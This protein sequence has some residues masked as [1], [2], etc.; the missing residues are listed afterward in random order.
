MSKKEVIVYTDGGARGNPGPA[1]SGAALFDTEG[2]ELATAKRFLG[3]ATNNVAEYTAIIIG[4][5]LAAE[6]GATH[7][8]V[9][10]DS[11]LACK[12]LNREYRVKN[13]QLA[14]LFMRVRGAEGPF[15]SVRYVHVRREQN[16]RADEL[17]N[18]AID[19][20]EG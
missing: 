7:V 17:V 3:E 11:E 14:K 16:K 13:E 8:E 6:Q 15:A 19:E 4:L 12:Q 10:M 5:E 9:R 20:A 1:G 18:I 2:N